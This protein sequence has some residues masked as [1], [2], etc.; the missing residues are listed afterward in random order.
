LYDV[1]L[2]AGA[3]RTALLAFNR[4]CSKP[5]L[6][7]EEVARIARS[8]AKGKERRATFL[9]GLLGEVESWHDDRDEPYITLTQDG[10]KENWPL[11]GRAWRHWL[12]KRCY[13]AAGELLG[14]NALA[15]QVNVLE[16]RAVFG[17]PRHTAHRRV[18]GHGDKIYL[19]LC[20]EHW[21][22]VELGP[23]A[24]PVV[25]TPP[26]KFRRAEP[27]LPPPVP[28]RTDPARLGGLLRPFLNVRDD[29]WPLV[30]AWL[31]AVLLPDGPYPM[32]KLHGEQGT[33]KSTNAR[34]ER[35]L[36]EPNAAPSRAEPRTE[37]DLVLAANNAWVVCL[38]NLSYLP[39]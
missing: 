10:H 7:G 22:A 23:D 5:P 8:A 32:L 35:A 19:D 28:E 1:G 16:G 34:V 13:D 3:V 11:R 18:A 33:A 12:G 2:S 30:A 14:A 24:W 38:D 17:G 21:R 20:D 31:A 6:P 29:N 4:Q 37:H 25:D 36:I 39:P 9:D 15:D 27:V 26:V